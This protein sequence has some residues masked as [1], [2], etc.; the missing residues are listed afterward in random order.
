VTWGHVFTMT[1]LNLSSGCMGAHVSEVTLPDVPLNLKIARIKEGYAKPKRGKLG[2][3]MFS[4][5][6]IH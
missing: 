6:G 5:R 3:R 2:F 4:D 1:A